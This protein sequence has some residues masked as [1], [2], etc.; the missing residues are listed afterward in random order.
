ME[1]LHPITKEITTMLMFIG[2]APA[3]TAGGIKVTTIM[4]IS[5]TL[6]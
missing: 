2:G 3:S 4:R 5:T 6:I 1:N